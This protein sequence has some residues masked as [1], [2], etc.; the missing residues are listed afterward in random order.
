L[1]G[2]ARLR[3]LAALGGCVVPS[4]FL[5]EAI[6]GGL[7]PE[8]PEGSLL[9][10]GRAMLAALAAD[11]VADGAVVVRSTWDRRLGAAPALPVEWTLVDGPDGALRE[12][13]RQS[14]RVDRVLAIAPETGGLLESLAVRV[15][16][17]GGVWAGCRPEAIALCADKLRLAEHL[18]QAGVPTLPTLPVESFRGPGAG[19]WP[20]GW[21][22]TLVVKPR[23]GAGSQGIAV[24][25]GR[26]EWLVR[27]ANTPGNEI[28][29]PFVEGASLSLAVLVAPSG[30]GGEPGRIEPLG[31]ATQRL[32]R[33]GRL[34]Y[35]GGELPCREW[36]LEPAVAVVR[37]ALAT[38][39]GLA[40]YVG[41]DLIWP[42]GAAA[43]L[44]C[45]INPRLTT[46]YVGYRVLYGP[47]LGRSV[48][49]PEVFAGAAP[50]AVR[51]VFG[52]EGRVTLQGDALAAVHQSGER[53]R[54][55]DP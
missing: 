54:T 24:V 15:I 20:D 23:D 30:S 7:C 13:E 46:S 47:A 53:E 28:I 33:D 36:P 11:L 42:R 4:L 2:D 34:S 19:G 26:D 48:V 45:E 12:L 41:C 16:R 14:P 3:T 52:A 5:L 50:N 35:E 27:C 21:G 43:P 55:T 17:A 32:S 25:R 1:R 39:S 8:R 51:V 37:S 9:R 18:A 40:G 44:V 6:C 49:W 10:E 38:V 31:L 22:E 29:Q